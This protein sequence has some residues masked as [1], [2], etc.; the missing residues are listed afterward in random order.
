MIFCLRQKQA[1]NFYFRIVKAVLLDFTGWAW[2]NY[3]KMEQHVWLD[4]KVLKILKVEVAFLS[5]LMIREPSMKGIRS[6]PSL[7][8]GKRLQP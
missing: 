7:N 6:R 8:Q 1:Q 5:M 2:V 4:E 3:R